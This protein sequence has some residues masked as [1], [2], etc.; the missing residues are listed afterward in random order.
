MRGERFQAIIL[1]RAVPIGHKDGGEE[2]GLIIQKLRIPPATSITTSMVLS[3]LD[4]GQLSVY[5]WTKTGGLVI[6]PNRLRSA[7]LCWERQ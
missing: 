3:P 2:G 1:A 7:V 4:F 5:D 6:G